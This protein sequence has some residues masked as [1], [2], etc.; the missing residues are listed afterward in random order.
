M[1]ASSDRLIEILHS[2]Y[3]RDPK[4]FRKFLPGAAELLP[5]RPPP[6]SRPKSPFGLTE[7]ERAYHRKGLE[8]VSR[9]LN[10]GAI[11]AEEAAKGLQH[12]ADLIK[13][14]AFTEEVNYELLKALVKAATGKSPASYKVKTTVPLGEGGPV[15]EQ[16]SVIVGVHLDLEVNGRLVSVSINPK[17]VRKR[18]EMM[19]IIGIGRDDQTDVALRHDDYLA[20]QDPHG[21]F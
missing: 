1:S 6:R 10:D 15:V 9:K 17:E 18:R 5:E 7:R 14:D 16:I 21:R 13:D 11:S 19:K 20:M 2:K 8:E 4:G 3:S 12:C